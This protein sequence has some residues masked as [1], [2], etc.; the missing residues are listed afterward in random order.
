MTGF[1]VYCWWVFSPSILPFKS[2]CHLSV[3]NEL[4]IHNNYTTKLL[5]HRSPMLYHVVT[6]HTV[7][8][9]GQDITVLSPL[10]TAKSTVTTCT[11]LVNCVASHFA[12]SSCQQ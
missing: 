5:F 11:Q 9:Q 7:T 8:T 1:D 4:C 10:L 3:K 12:A 6:M 2:L